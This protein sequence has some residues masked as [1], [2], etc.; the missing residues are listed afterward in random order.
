MPDQMMSIQEFGALIKTKYPEY[1]SYADDDIAKKVLE[2]YPEY[3]PRVRMEEEVT[4]PQPQ[5]SPEPIVKDPTVPSPNPTAPPPPSAKPQISG[6]GRS[7]ASK[8]FSTMRDTAYGGPESLLPQIRGLTAPALPEYKSLNVPPPTEGYQDPEAS[9]GQISAEPAYNAIRQ[10]S[11]V[12]GALADYALGKVAGAGAKLIGGRFPRV[13]A[14]LGG[15]GEALPEVAPPAQ[16][17]PKELP[18]SPLD[19]P[20]A[21]IELGSKA[22]DIVGPNQVTDMRGTRFY[23]GQ[24][25]TTDVKNAYPVANPLASKLQ[26]KATSKALPP[27]VIDVPAE[28]VAQ[29]A[30]SEFQAPPVPDPRLPAKY[31]PVEEPG[32]YTGTGQVEPMPN[33]LKQAQEQAVP[34]IKASN[35]SPRPLP[36]DPNDLRG[37]FQTGPDLVETVPESAV[38]V[39]PSKKEDLIPG[40]TKYEKTLNLMGEAKSIKASADVSAP[41]RQGF[42][43][44]SRP[45]FYKNIPNMLKSFVSEEAATKTKEAI[46]S[47]PNYELMKEVGLAVGGKEESFAQMKLAEKIPALGR[48]VK[49]SDRAYTTFLTKLRADIFDNVIETAAKQGY[50]KSA[51]APGV[52]DWINVTTGRGDLGKLEPIARELNATFFSPRFASSRLQLLG[53]PIKYMNANPVVRQMIIRDMLGTTAIYTGLGTAAAVAGAEVGHDPRGTDFGKFK[54]GDTRFDLGAGV[55]QYIRLGAELASGQKLTQKGSVI[56]LKESGPG[57]RS[58]YEEADQFRR[59]KMAPIPGIVEDWL[60]GTDFAGNKFNASKEVMDLFIPMVSQDIID[61]AKSNPNLL[62]PAVPISTFGGGVQTYGQRPRKRAYQ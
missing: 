17:R 32:Y 13:A 47:S 15:G 48:I 7:V 30:A 46:A 54:V 20:P 37:V 21:E 1:Q 58:K 8:I 9:Y 36:K 42:F 25:G 52:A 40:K 55:L 33:T 3:R 38:N 24:G 34:G 53:S 23:A 10:S 49:G 26:T 62:L 29:Q 59:G 28:R 18:P 12:T 5:P 41:L 31:R 57:K 27:E 51:V 56:D 16:F 61:V 22:R 45:E 43:T 35:I 2:K 4:P 14:L 11:S 19:V 6:D 39:T 44:S 50:D 60:R